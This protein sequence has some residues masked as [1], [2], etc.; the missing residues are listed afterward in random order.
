MES[1]SHPTLYWLTT[2]GI[3]ILFS[4]VTFWVK[5]WIGQQDRQ[6]EEWLKQG[7]VVTR[8]RLEIFCNQSRSKCPAGAGFNLLCDW[9][10]GIMDKGG[11][12]ARNEHT[13]I[14]KEITKEVANH[15]T[16]RIEE[17]FNHHREWVGQELKL[18]IQEQSSLRDLVK[19]QIRVEANRWDQHDE[20]AGKPTSDAE[21]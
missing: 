11:P 4:I 5:R 18:I 19:R 17:L 12:L 1:A 6:Q 14:C 8:E 16:D 2:G 13:A 15:F 10:E 9:R 21:L 7:G 20:R 3:T